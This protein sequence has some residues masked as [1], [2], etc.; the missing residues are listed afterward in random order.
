[1]HRSSTVQ[2]RGRVTLPN[3]VRQALHVAPGDDVVFVETGP[4]RFEVR[5]RA[6]RVALLHSA[7]RPLQ[8]AGQPSAR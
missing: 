1:M 7:R 5:A 2:T 3:S 4:G 8:S 6:Q